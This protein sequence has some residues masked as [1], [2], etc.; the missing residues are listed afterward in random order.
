MRLGILIIIGLI[1]NKFG[2][3][4]KS[5]NDWHKQ[6]TEDENRERFKVQESGVKVQESRFKSQVKTFLLTVYISLFTIQKKR[7][8]DNQHPAKHCKQLKFI[9]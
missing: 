5:K 3:G 6:E 8:A 1:S 9:I 4:K 2:Y 7:D